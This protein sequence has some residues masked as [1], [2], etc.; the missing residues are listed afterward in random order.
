MIKK[1]TPIPRLPVHFDFDIEDGFMKV[2]ISDEGIVVDV[3][4]NHVDGEILEATL[5]RTVDELA[6]LVYAV[7]V[8]C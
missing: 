1:A 8:I 5:C 7:G 3:Y 4:K 2:F 6:D